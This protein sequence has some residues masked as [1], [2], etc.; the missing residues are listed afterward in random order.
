[1]EENLEIMN[2]ELVETTEEE[3]EI[4]YDEEGADEYE[5]D[6]LTSVLATT[7]VVAIVGGAA[8]GIYRFGKWAKSKVCAFK[9]KKAKDAAIEEGGS[10][11]N[12]ADSEQDSEG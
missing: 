9:E 12:E 2:E 5:G 10:T 11:T 8:Y 4:V 1:M 6:A 7:G 3:P